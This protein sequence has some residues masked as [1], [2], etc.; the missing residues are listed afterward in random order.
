VTEPERM[1]VL[2]QRDLPHRNV[3][4][5]RRQL[6]VGLL[7]GVMSIPR[8]AT[9]HLIQRFL[10]RIASFH[11]SGL[12]PDDMNRL[13]TFYVHVSSRNE[14]RCRRGEPNNSARGDRTISA[15]RGRPTEQIGRYRVTR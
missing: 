13:D 9:N 3:E 4:P 5:L 1:A 12:F 10:R 11:R 8:I 2:V 7:H 15:C 6:L 14:F